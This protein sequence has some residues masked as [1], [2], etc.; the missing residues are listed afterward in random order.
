MENYKILWI[1]DEFEEDEQFFKGE[2]SEVED[3]FKHC[4]E[5]NITKYY[6]YKQIKVEDLDQ[7][8]LI[9]TDYNLDEGEGKGIDLV[10]EINENLYLGDII[11]YSDN[12]EITKKTS[13]LDPLEHYNYSK[14]VYKR[15]NLFSA[16]IETIGRSTKYYSDIVIL[17][18]L[19]L[20]D[21]VQLE[22]K[23]NE[24]LIKIY[25]P[26]DKK[27][28]KNELIENPYLTFFAKRDVL[29]NY[30]KRLEEE[31]KPVERLKE[32]YTLL[33]KIQK[34]R[35]KFAHYKYDKLKKKLISGNSDSGELTPTE[36]KR[37]RKD[38]KKCSL[39]INKEIREIK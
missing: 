27:F 14:V 3:K 13:V 16:I 38:I 37:L 7:Y 26:K 5:I 25:Q 31:G 15:T 1:D 19:I 24:L 30:K 8:D 20:E 39:L 22:N 33:S 6:S 2:I 32:I 12:E 36:I 10:K 28:F 18:G 17:R 29:V 35:N 4:M 34:D 11:L 21:S 9:I 23:L